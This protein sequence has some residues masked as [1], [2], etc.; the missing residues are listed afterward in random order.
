M[1]LSRPPGSMEPPAV[2]PGAPSRLGPHRRRTLGRMGWLPEAPAVVLVALTLSA[3]LFLI[4]VALPT[5]GVAGFTS[6]ALAVVGFNAAGDQDHP[7][8]PLL[9]VI[10]AVC[11]WTILLVGQW[12]APASQLVAAGLFAAGSVGYGL[13]ARDPA[14]VALGVATSAALP[15]CF[16]PLL[17][18]ASRLRQLP[19]Q[20]GME[21][22]VGRR[23]TV[24]QWADLAGTVRLDGSLWNARSR[25]P[26]APG[27]AVV[28]EGFTAMTVHVALG[29]PVP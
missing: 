13:L 21:A 16:G 9:L 15:F 11:L 27:T 5:L 8:W 14:T 4:E 3:A 20:L 2:V 10:A 29:A 7:W 28:V 6:L 17:R 24:V 12:A 18:A 1:V 22:M 23:G 25:L 19:P 26:L